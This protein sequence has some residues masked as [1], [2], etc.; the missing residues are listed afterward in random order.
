MKPRTNREIRFRSTVLFSSV[1][2][3]VMTIATDARAIDCRTS[4]GAGSPWAWRQID[5][6]RCWYKGTAGIDKKRLRWPAKP[7]TAARPKPAKQLLTA[8]PGNDELLETVWPPT[9]T[10]DN[11]FNGDKQQ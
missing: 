7:A 8:P 4:Q 10:F 1:A 3:T 2:M 9:D 11:R 6:K 5:G